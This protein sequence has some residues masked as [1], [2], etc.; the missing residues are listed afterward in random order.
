MKKEDGTN[1]ADNLVRA[2]ENLQGRKGSAIEAKRAEFEA[3]LF[4]PDLPEE[5]TFAWNAFHELN[6][7][8]GSNG[9]GVNPITY[10]EIDAYVRL[11]GKV[12]LPYEINAI[13]VIDACFLKAQDNLRKTAQ[14]TKQSGSAN[15]AQPA[16]AKKGR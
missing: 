8:R 2:L 5:Y 10:L 12:L 16:P 15:T 11:T 14:K 7:S 6:G 3:K 4:L 1:E 9:F 13:N